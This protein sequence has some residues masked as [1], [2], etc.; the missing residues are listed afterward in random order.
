M[1]AKKKLPFIDK[2]FLTINCL[3]CLALLVSYLAPFT[4]PK[5]CSFVALFGLAYPPLLLANLIITCYWLLR[6]SRYVLLSPVCILIGWKVLTATIGF[7]KASD[8]IARP[9]A[10]SSIRMMTYNVHEFKRYGA[11]HDTSTKHE[12]LQI[13]QQQQPDIIGFQ[14]FFS[15]KKGKFDMIDSIKKV[16]NV[17]YYYFEPFTRN[18]RKATGMAIFSRFPIVNE[19]IVLLSDSSN[20]NQCLYVDIKRNSSLF[21]VYS[22]HLKSIRFDPEDYDYIDSVSKDGK[23]DMHSTERLGSKLIK[24]FKRRSEQMQKIK[25]HSLKCPYPYI[26]SGDFNDTP[27]SYSMNQMRKGLK[28]AFSEKGSGLGKTYNG[29]F[30]NYQIDYIMANN[31][32]DIETYKVIERKLSDHYPVRS[33]LLLR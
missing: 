4:D 19:G 18:A 13:L 21:R 25:D 32:F 28:N 24:A 11:K 16:L 33:D 3:L 31:R 9:Q 14:E 26:I 2:L 1:K 7:H 5:E 8:D 6:R 10:A 20:E 29:D 23:P 30:P 17:N 22:V 12:I 15:R 27:A